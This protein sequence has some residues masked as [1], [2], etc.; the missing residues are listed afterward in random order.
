MPSL[1]MHNV[2]DYRNGKTMTR[3]AIAKRQAFRINF[4]YLLPIVL[5]H[6]ICTTFDSL[7]GICIMYIKFAAL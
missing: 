6:Y 1:N 3:R 7:N 4:E 2:T 5:A